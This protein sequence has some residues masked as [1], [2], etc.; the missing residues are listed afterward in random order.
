MAL[1]GLDP[2]DPTPGFFRHL[3]PAAGQSPGISPAYRVLL[4]GNK[5]SAGSETVDTLGTFIADDADAQ[6]RMGLRSELYAMYLQFTSIDRTAETYFVAVTESVGAEAFASFTFGAGPATVNSTVEVEG[7]HGEIFEVAITQGD[8]AS[9]VADNVRAAFANAAEGTFPIIG[10]GVSPIVTGTYIHA[11]PRGTL[12]INRMRM[13]FSV[14]CGLTVAKGAVTAGTVPDDATAAYAAAAAGEFYF[15]VFPFHAT[16]AVTPTDNQ[17]GEGIH[18]T[19]GVVTRGTPSGGQEETVHVGLVG[20]QAEAAAVA[21]SAGAN[22][23]RAYFY[24]AENN[25]LIP[26]QIAAQSAAIFRRL[27]VTH[28]A[29]PGAVL[30]T[31]TDQTPMSIPDPFDPTDRPTPAEIRADLNSGVTPIAFRTSGQS[32]IPRIITS[33][34]LNSVGNTDFR[35][36]EGHITPVI[37]FFW[38]QIELWYSE[39]AQPLISENLAEG[40]KPFPLTSTP[41][42]IEQG[43]RTV[44]RDLAGA[45]PVSGIFRGPILA[46]GRL[47]EMLDSVAVTKFTAGF[48]ARAHVFAV[49]HLIKGLTTIEEG[50]P[51]Y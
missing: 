14:P 1:P 43:I 5:T 8:I 28:P 19:N 34:S 22:S 16:A 41:R 38:A 20:T 26:A 32:F 33:R 39:N 23:T 49:E 17:I 3:V 9:D 40:Q 12:P 31:S 42:Q 35:A 37:D 2:N 25:D 44:I 27:T 21:T 48:D 18:G 6:A 30:Y 15:R 4:F 51:A 36:R 29:M 46:P 11:G 47:Q 45:T 24:R 50:S 13:D 7:V 10:S